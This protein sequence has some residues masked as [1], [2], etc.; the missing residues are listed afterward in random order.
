MSYEFAEFVPSLIYSLIVILI[1]ARPLMT[2][3]YGINEHL[4]AY[5]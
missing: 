5:C 3:F 2:S 1:T 4:F